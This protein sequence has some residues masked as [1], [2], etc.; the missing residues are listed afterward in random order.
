M[1][2]NVE[3]DLLCSLA[4]QLYLA[5]GLLTLCRYRDRGGQDEQEMIAR[6][7]NVT[8]EVAKQLPIII[9]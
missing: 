5:S 3:V 6:E 9:L 8:A 4:D 7:H 2:E 1:Q